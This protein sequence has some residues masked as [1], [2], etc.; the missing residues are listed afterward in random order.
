MN[1]DAAIVLYAEDSEDD[2]FLM[3]RAF[4]KLKFPGKLVVVTHGL[5]ARHYLEGTGSY[6]D[7][8]RHPLPRVL[9]LDIKMPHLS[10]LDVLKWVRSNSAFRDL[11][12]FMLTSSSQPADVATAYENGANSYLVKPSNL[13]DFTNLVEDLA[14]ACRADRTTSL[15]TVRGAIPARRL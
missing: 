9:L 13:G 7:R 8:Q 15:P 11:P 2:A 1:P 6:A 10:G 4:T 5:E 14:A 3:Q 12:V